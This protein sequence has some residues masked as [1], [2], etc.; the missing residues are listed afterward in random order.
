MILLLRKAFLNVTGRLPDG[1]GTAIYYHSVKDD[2]KEKFRR[3]MNVLKNSA[4]PLSASYSGSIPKG[5]NCVILTFD[6]GFK[7]LIENAIPEL[8]RLKIPCVIF[9]PVK[10]L[11]Q[12][13]GWEF[14]M[15][16]NDEN[17]EIMTPGDIKNL[18]GDYVLLGSHS[19]SHRIMTDLNPLELK[20]EFAKSK[21]TLESISGKYVHLFSFPYGA[22]SSGLI[23]QALA[24]GYKRVF[25]GSY[26]VFTSE[27]SGPVVG[28]VR[29]DPSDS[30]LEFRLKILGAYGWMRHFRRLKEKFSGLK[31]TNGKT[32]KDAS[33]FTGNQ[34]LK[35]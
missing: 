6:D 31:D 11:G 21:E 33:Y 22:C 19:F 13:P 32:K 26:E 1:R 7:S 3:Q 8:L 27:I 23:E 5:K 10:Y 14:N 2:E 35:N 30:I 28:R 29:V 12:R 16:F 34:L 15:R 9:F 25:T 24:A 18:P 17:E 20:E 4:V